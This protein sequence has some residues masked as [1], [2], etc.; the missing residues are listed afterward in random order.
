MFKCA[1]CG[2]CCRSLDKSDLY[3]WLDKGNGVCKYLQGNFCSVYEI[4]PVTCRVDGYFEQNLKNVMD[5]DEYYRLN[6]NACNQLKN[7]I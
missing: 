2:E 5:K 4:R 3:S 6:Y 1:C 7:K